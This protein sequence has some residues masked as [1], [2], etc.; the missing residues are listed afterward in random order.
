MRAWDGM[1]NTGSPSAAIGP[2]HLSEIMWYD[3]PI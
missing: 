2:S 1:P 3:V